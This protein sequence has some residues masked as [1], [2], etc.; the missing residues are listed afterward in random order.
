MRSGKRFY[1]DV[2][3][4]VFGRRDVA[5]RRGRSAMQSSSAA[6]LRNDEN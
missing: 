4:K 1:T 3:G 6:A 2:E 5:M